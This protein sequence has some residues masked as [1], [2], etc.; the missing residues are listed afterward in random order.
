[1]STF[2][3][4]LN[5]WWIYSTTWNL[6]TQIRT[7][8]WSVFSYFYFYW[9]YRESWWDWIKSKY[10]V[11]DYYRLIYKKSFVASGSSCVSHGNFVKSIKI[12]YIYYVSY[13]ICCCLNLIFSYN[14][15]INLLGF[16]KDLLNLVKIYHI[17][18]YSFR[19]F[20]MFF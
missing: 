18:S 4:R 9:S 8:L 12:Y 14:I 17:L 11:K 16:Y 20:V 3:Y 2:L 19:V 10:P 15:Y 5:L 1:M 7:V 6:K 13:G